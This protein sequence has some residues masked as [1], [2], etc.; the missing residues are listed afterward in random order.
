MKRHVNKVDFDPVVHAMIIQ[1]SIYTS[2]FILLICSYPLHVLCVF[3]ECV[4]LLS[5]LPNANQLADM[6]IKYCI[7]NIFATSRD[8]QSTIS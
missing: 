4:V 1:R 6:T 5:V 8:N 7:L 2:D 3:N